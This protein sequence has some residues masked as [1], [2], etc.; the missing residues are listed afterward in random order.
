MIQNDFL[1]IEP[2]IS[3]LCDT[4]FCAAELEDTFFRNSLEFHVK[5]ADHLFYNLDLPNYVVK[6]QEQLEK[7]ELVAAV[8]SKL[9]A[10]VMY[11]NVY[12]EFLIKKESLIFDVLFSDSL[13]FDQQLLKVFYSLFSSINKLDGLKVR[14]LRFTSGVI[15]KII[16][17]RSNKNNLLGLL[18]SVKES[19]DQTI[20]VSFNDD[21]KFKTATKEIFNKVFNS[22]PTYVSE[23]LSQQIDN[24]MRIQPDERTFYSELEKFLV[25]N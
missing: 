15:G 9:N 4:N 1:K 22:N 10:K 12:D 18:V 21:D 19:F 20:V 16:D 24:V 13:S 23:A 25:S 3:V 6:I 17:D 8:F 14:W 7:E 5:L 11:D 2:L